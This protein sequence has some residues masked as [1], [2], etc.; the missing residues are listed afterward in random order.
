VADVAGAAGVVGLAGAAGVGLPARDPVRFT[1]GPLGAAARRFRFM[2]FWYRRAMSF[3]LF[4]AKLP[5]AFKAAKTG[6]ACFSRLT[7]IAAILGKPL[8]IPPTCLE[9][10]TF[11]F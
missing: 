4:A 8:P 9:A 2:Y 11:T 7:P 5:P 1:L 6:F 3:D 10:A